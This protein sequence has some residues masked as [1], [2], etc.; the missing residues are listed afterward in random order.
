[1]NKDELIE[2]IIDTFT[3][4]GS[5]DP[6]DTCYAHPITLAEAKSYLNEL[7]ANEKTDLEPEEWL[8]AEIT[9]A[10]YME[11]FNCY[12]RRCRYEVTL[13]RLTEFIVDAEH[14]DLY[15]DFYGEYISYSDKVCYPTDWLTENME[16]PFTSED[17]T[18]LDL[19]TLGQN[20]PEFNP[21]KRF[22]WYDVTSHTIHSTN[23]PFASGLMSAQNFAEWILEERN[24][25]E[26]VTDTYM[27]NTDIDYIFHFWEV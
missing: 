4:M 26:Y 14:V 18:M 12:L 6:V 22:C 24:R 10:L 7:R 5:E 15:H 23:A 3:C 21:E 19:I 20:S 1:M 11:A 8:P 16:F 9:P 27:I 25:I 2:R 13:H 17:L